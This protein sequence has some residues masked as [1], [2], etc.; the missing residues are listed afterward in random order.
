M[1]TFCN[2]IAV[3]GSE[4]DFH[5]VSR[6]LI[7]LSERSKLC[8]EMI[9][10]IGALNSSRYDRLVIHKGPK[11][12]CQCSRCRLSPERGMFRNCYSWE[13]NEM[14]YDPTE[15][16]YDRSEPWM[17]VPPEI[18]LGHELVHAW[19]AASGNRHVMIDIEEESTVGIGAFK[20]KKYTENAIR[21]EYGLPLRPRY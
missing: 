15:P 7:T 16:M 10:E 6:S 20:D 14:I 17:I 12:V 1:H 9:E 13:H 11:I 18:A 3:D 5:F 8:K 21:K 19:N 4:E 2:G